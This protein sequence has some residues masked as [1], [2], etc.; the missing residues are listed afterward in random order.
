MLK[1]IYT[2]GHKYFIRNF[3]VYSLSFSK[4]INGNWYYSEIT[5]NIYNRFK[6]YH[7]ISGLLHQYQS[8][9]ICFLTTCKYKIFQI[10]QIKI[11]FDLFKRS[12]ISNTAIVSS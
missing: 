2:T 1:S 8:S 7:I 9:D 5:L 10:D 11:Y 6:L 3:S 4:H 12:A